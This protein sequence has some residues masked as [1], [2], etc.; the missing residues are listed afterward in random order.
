MPM[1]DEE[2]S[3]VIEI[4]DAAM[5][6][7]IAAIDRHVTQIEFF[8]SLQEKFDYRSVAGREYFALRASRV[9][10]A[11]GLESDLFR[12]VPGWGGS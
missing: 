1:E 2:V 12:G 8:R 11:E 6:R 3:A 4:T 5:D 9:P 7:K 10:P